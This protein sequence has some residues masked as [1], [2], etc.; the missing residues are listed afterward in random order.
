MIGIPGGKF[1]IG[2]KSILA[3]A[4]E[5]PV[6]EIELS[7][8][9]IE[10]HEVTFKEWDDYFK[11]MSLPQSKTIDGVTRATPQYID[12]TWGMV[13]SLRLPSIS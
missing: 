9:W 3:D 2:S 4:D 6:A 13:H 5:S 12:L 11:E 10:E 8:F 7:P 1:Q